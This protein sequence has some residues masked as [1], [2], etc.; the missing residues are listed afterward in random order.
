MALQVKKVNVWAG[1]MQDRP[2]GLARLLEGIAGAGTSLECVIARRQADKPGTGVV[3]VTPIGGKKAEAG[4]RMAGLSPAGNM[5]T[6]RVEGLDEKGIGAQ[7]AR[8]IADAG[9]NG[10]GVTA[11]VIGKRFVAYIGFDSVADA[12]RAAAAIRKMGRRK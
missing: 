7:M 1:E 5:A 3:F 4:A 11:A 12:D 9:I 6:L 2:G 10:R 8:A